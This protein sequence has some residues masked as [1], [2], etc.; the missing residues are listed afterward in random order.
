PHRSAAD[1][2]LLDARPDLLHRR[3]TPGGLRQHPAYE[4]PNPAGSAPGRGPAQ[5]LEPAVLRDIV[6]RAEQ[7]ECAVHHASGRHLLTERREMSLYSLRHANRSVKLAALL[8][9]LVLGFA[10][11]FAF[12]MVKTWSGLT[13]RGS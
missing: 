7:L 13:R 3:G 10:Y 11:G 6:G 5:P 8:F 1:A 12:L 2:H 9:L 4:L